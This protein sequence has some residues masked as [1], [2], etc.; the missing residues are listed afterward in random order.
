MKK[1]K[2][3]LLLF[4]LVP[5]SL[6][7]QNVTVTG[8][9][10]DRSGEIIIGAS[11]MEQGTTKGTITDIDGKYSISVSR[12]ATLQ[13]SYV[14]YATYTIALRNVGGARHS[15][16][17]V[18]DEDTRT[19]EEVVVVGY[20][21]QK[22]ADLTSAIATLSASEVLKVPGGIENALQGNVAGVNVSGGKIRIRG[23]SSI[24]G[25]TD[26]LWVV[27]GVIGGAVP[28][29]N[30]IETIQ[31]LKDAA[32]AAIYGVRGANGVIVVTTKKG[33]LGIPR[34][35]F[36]TYVGTGSPAK[37]IKM[38]DAYDYGVYVN[39][40]FYN[41]ATP[42]AQADGTWNL[43]VP[44]NN[45][46]PSQPMAKTDWWDEYFFPNFYQSYDLAIGGGSELVNYRLGATVTA[47]Q[48]Q[49][50]PRRS[51]GRNLYAVVQGT[52]GRFTYGG[53]AQLN[54]ND[55]RT[56][57]A[58]SLQNTLQLPSNEPVYD[59]NNKELNRGYYQTGMI[60]GMDIPNQAFFIHE[61]KTHSQTLSVMGNLFGE[62]KIVEWLKLKL[63]Y[64]NAISK[65]N[66]QHFRPRFVLASGGGGGIQDYNFLETTNRGY[67]RE[68]FEALLNFDKKIGSH[69]VS[70]VAGVT[71]ETFKTFNKS[72]SGRSQEMTDFGVENQFQ[73]NVSASGSESENAYYSFLARVMYSYE[74]KYMFTANF[75]A[76]ES[77]KF[78]PGKR[79]GYFPSFSVGWRISDEAWL[80]KRTSSWL[81]SLKL[82]AT[83]GWIGSDL[84]VGNY[85]YQEVVNSVGYFY[86]FGPQ[87]ENMA[88]SNYPAPRPSTIT[89]KNLSWETTRD[90]GF[91][92][93]LSALNQ[94]LT[95]TFDYYNR[96]ISDM[97]LN[98]QLPLSVGN[99]GYFAN[100][101]V[102]MNIG[103]MTNWGLELQG[104]WRDNKGGL[105]YAVSPNFSLYRNK[106]VN[107][108]NT[109]FLA[110]GSTRFNGAN[111]TRTAVGLPVAQFWGYKTEGLF[112]TDEAAAN[113]VNANGQRLQP[114]A[115]AGDIKYLDLDGNGSIGEED[116]TY[117]GSSIPDVS[118]GLNLYLQYKGFD[119]SMLL[120]GDLGIDVYNNWK[121]TLLAG[122]AVHNQMADIK[123]AFRGKAVSFTTSGGETIAL[124]AN[125]NTSIPRIVNGDPN[126][127]SM[128][129]SDYFV[130]DASYLRCNNITLGYALPKALLSAMKFENVR[131]YAGVKNPFTI[132]SYSMFD[133]QVPNGGSTLDRGVDGQFYDFT[134]TYWSQREFFAGLQLAF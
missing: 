107:I 79:W 60:D 73:D 42:Q 62:F 70:G 80:K 124:P 44:A 51:N 90:A 115:A 33:N 96:R 40:L 103:S 131:I 23:T 6:S 11:I 57:S 77:S 54:Y 34:I 88:D 95:I 28:N 67:D 16:N 129:S 104:T 99:S 102:M 31:V 37:R 27:D 83:L 87:T 125:T 3:L 130:E 49:S 110:G 10:T 56:T 47:D 105:I 127:N 43:V 101:S 72:F 9:V 7:A 126:Q 68:M 106:V 118:V 71:S 91:G 78:A 21:T 119:L 89:N 14:G 13:V 53:R 84:G 19:L 8:I 30:E 81:N 116:K 20:G 66:S 98:V 12:T 26:P 55:N 4:L 132:T 93:D 15:L 134:G 24:T 38:L 120:Q 75:R 59:D 18:L 41:A 100:P 64:T 39:E 50:L 65:A 94:K 97:L 82:R 69:S 86:T 17:I 52:K 61:D 36:N 32:S 85:A 121:Q 117:I 25:N 112:G 63:T 45:A 113:Y 76:D 1:N 22:K 122:R 123:N 111:V 109:D 92:F 114:S 2:F 35:N 58:G 74:G 128:R 133:P 46:K 108:G 48:R 29:D 5:L